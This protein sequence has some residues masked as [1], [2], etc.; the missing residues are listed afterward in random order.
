M[1]PKSPDVRPARRR[2]LIAAAMAAALAAT[3]G[4]AHAQSGISTARD[5]ETEK[6]ISDY[7]API[8]KAAGVDKPKINLVIA[9]DFNA[10][11]T[12]GNRLWVNTGTIIQSD[13]PNELIGVLA[14]ETGHVAADDIAQ[15][16]QVIQET[17]SAMLI[18]GLLS[19][20]AATAAGSVI[21]GD[22]ATQA[23]AGVFSGIGQ[24]G[25]RAILRYKREQEAAADRAAVNYLNA[26]GQSPAGMLASLNR[27]ANQNLFAVQR[28][29]PYLQ[30]H[31][32]PRDR[33]VTI[34]NLARQSK[35]FGKKDSAALQARH[36]LV[37]AKL[38]GFTMSQ[39]DVYRIYPRGDQ[40]LPARYARAISEYRNGRRQEALRLIDG[41]IGAN[42]KNP[43][44][45][46]LK[47]QALLESGNPRAAVPELRQ[48]VSLSGNSGL[49]GIMLGQALV[50]LGDRGSASEAVKVLTRGL[51]DA[52]RA[53]SGYRALARAY[54]ILDDVGMAQLVTAEG[55]VIDGQ[56]G[57][58]KI[59]ATRAQ[60]KLKKGS[61]PWLRADDI[62]AYKPRKTR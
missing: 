46:E 7:L 51:R 39:G 40:S 14:H 44:F 38:V 11:V 32:F 54:A 9:P 22:A 16:Q 43:Y 30:S 34:E 26:T 56:L 61:P 33:A 42:P 25:T 45:H 60:A 41:L 24:I 4:A 10:F 12:P 18:A 20:G 31:P 53:S 48:A 59:Q 21:G 55:L 2:P 27:L 49:I 19:I 6:L 3:T 13:T 29:N 15:L 50:A 17:R 52:P 37:R 62:I 47:G 35:Y 1:D 28:A 36:D 5:A 58:A 23:G 57:E 8:I